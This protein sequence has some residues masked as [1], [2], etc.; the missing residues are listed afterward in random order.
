MARLTESFGAIGS[1]SARQAALQL[2]LNP[3]AFG[4]EKAFEP[5]WMQIIHVMLKALDNPRHGNLRYTIFWNLLHDVD[6][7]QPAAIEFAKGLTDRLARVKYTKRTRGLIEHWLE[8]YR[9]G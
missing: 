8:R 6:V 7:P 5:F 9:S 4:I 3:F 1:Q 2:V